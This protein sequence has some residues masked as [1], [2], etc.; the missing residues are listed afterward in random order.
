MW[1]MD[2]AV[3]A[4][5]LDGNV[6][7]FNSTL[8]MN[9]K[10][11]NFTQGKRFDLLKKIAIKENAF[12]GMLE[13]KVVKVG[14]IV[15]TSMERKKSDLRGWEDTYTGGFTFS[16]KY[17]GAALSETQI[18]LGHYFIVVWPS[19]C[20]RD[21]HFD[22]PSRDQVAPRQRAPNVGM[23]LTCPVS[24]V[25]LAAADHRKEVPMQEIITLKDGASAPVLTHQ[26]EIEFSDEARRAKYQ[27]V[28]LVSFV[29]D[30]D[31]LPKNINVV[32]SLGMGL[33][34]KAIEAVGQWKFK[35]GMKNCKPVPVRMNVE[36]SFRL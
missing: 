28:A 19:A 14:E 10:Y 11:C 16:G 33:D 24:T 31:G 4:Y 32:R 22:S 18:E 6:L 7:S 15:I 5:E 36:V 34:E 27:G 1:M 3:P 12:G 35:P 30:I 13:I 17:A 2:H 29:V 20:E 26:V 8:S 21:I 25:D 9:D 23:S